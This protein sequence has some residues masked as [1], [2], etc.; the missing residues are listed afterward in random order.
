MKLPLFSQCDSADKNGQLIPNKGGCQGHR[1]LGEYPLCAQRVFIGQA[2]C[3][4]Q[5]TFTWEWWE[6]ELR[7][8]KK[9]NSGLNSTLAPGIATHKKLRL[10]SK[11][12]P[13]GNH[14]AACLCSGM[15]SGMLSP[16]P[17]VTH[18]F[19][20]KQACEWHFSET[21]LFMRWVETVNARLGAC[22]EITLSPRPCS[23]SSETT[24]LGYA[25]HGCCV[26]PACLYL[27]GTLLGQPGEE[28]TQE[29]CDMLGRWNTRYSISWVDTWVS[30]KCVALVFKD[31]KKE[32]RSRDAWGGPELC[33]WNPRRKMISHD[34]KSQT[35]AT[36]TKMEGRR[37]RVWI[38]I[39]QQ[40]SRSP[41]QNI[42]H[43]SATVFLHPL[44]KTFNQL[45]ETHTEPKQGCQQCLLWHH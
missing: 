21:V 2:E 5:M 13:Y 41:Y 24:C 32:L 3:G 39:K 29:T 33:D 40:L 14:A 11:P 38:E 10:P 16:E 22:L 45:A 7:N 18:S 23:T 27:S 25:M 31:V 35:L 17:C 15:R 4:N 43:I 44:Q 34:K 37:P 28:M 42:N 20:V 1:Q 8:H 6:K 30:W 12:S 26:L 19:P 36:L 9:Q